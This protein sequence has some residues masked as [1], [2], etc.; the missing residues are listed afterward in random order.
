[1]HFF[2]IDEAGCTGE[3]LSNQQQPVFVAGGLIVREEGWNKTKETFAGLVSA[4]FEGNVPEGFELHSYELLSPKGDGPFAGH[5]R[6]RRLHAEQHHS[7]SPCSKQ[8][9]TVS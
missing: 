5:S 4:Y 9:V 2:Y 8:L 1:M 6:V 7:S 3:D